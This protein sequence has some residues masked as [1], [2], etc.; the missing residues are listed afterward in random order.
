[1]I[2]ISSYIIFI[3]ILLFLLIFFVTIIKFIAF[4]III[5]V[6]TIIIII[7]AISSY[8][9]ATKLHLISVFVDVFIQF[10]T[11]TLREEILAG[12]KFGGFG[13]FDKSPPN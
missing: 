6:T 12:R 7:I 13:S 1:M 5:M 8:G 10:C 9:I 3:V 11:D 2:F 4:A